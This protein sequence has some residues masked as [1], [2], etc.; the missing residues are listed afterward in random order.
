MEDSLAWNR[1]VCVTGK[2]EGAGLYFLLYGLLYGL[3]TI[4]RLL[5][6]YNAHIQIYTDGAKNPETEATGFGVVMP[7]KGTGFQLVNI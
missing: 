6:K 4:I 2:K 1:L 7:D 3:L 5:E